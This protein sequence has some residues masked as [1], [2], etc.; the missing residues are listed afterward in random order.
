[1]R[2]HEFAA[3]LR[4][5]GLAAEAVRAQQDALA[6]VLTALPG[7]G[8]GLSAP[9]AP[10]APRCAFVPGRIEIV[11]KHT[12]YAG[13][14]SLVCA[15]DRGFT[16]AWCP[17]P[18]A[19]L[20]VLDAVSGESVEADLAAGGTPGGAAWATYVAAVA[21]RAIRNFDARR[22]VDLAFASN[23]PPAA[24]LSSSSALLITVFLALGDAND[25]VRHPAVLA[26]CATRESLA[27]YLATVENGSG[28]GALAGDTGVG[29]RGG[30]Q[31]HT[32][33]LASHAGRLAQ[34]AYRPTRRER[35]IACPPGLVFAV[36][37]S[38][39]AAEKTGAALEAYNRAARATEVVL[40]RWNTAHG[41]AD[42]TLAAACASGPGGA[43]AVRREAGRVDADGWDPNRLLARVDQ[44]LLET[45]EV[46]P[47]TGDALA[48]G[49]L[50]RLGAIV[51]RSQ[52]AAE[53]WLDNQVPETVALQ[54]LARVAGAHAASAFGAG[55]GGSVWAL[56]D[57]AG[58][59]AFLERWRRA[60]AVAHPD[61]SR[62]AG[63]LLTPPGPGA[64]CGW[65]PP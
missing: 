20:R 24:G 9:R 42:A 10:A 36:A 13:G 58:A 55:F 8:A 31:D 59:D 60:Y 28:F 52:Q 43:A 12:D 56:V 2:S 54:R 3:A 40:A 21:R 62:R 22:G 47:G 53:T 27:A 39:I 11:G 5:A 33:I 57:A 30:S 63:F 49:D 1:V 19:R 23:L 4:R 16:A 46:V 18:D 45:T 64:V 15:V 48:A 26:H 61:A 29:T 38:G 17:R 32:A 25:L 34:F 7:T 41:R 44:F 14:R 51:D 50:A 35:D 37:A 6:R 65:L